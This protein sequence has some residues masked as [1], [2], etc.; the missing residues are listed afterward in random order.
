MIGYARKIKDFNTQ[1]AD[2]NITMI[3]YENY[4]HY[5]SCGHRLAFS[6]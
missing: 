2:K 1:V 4:Y 3:H 5:Y 6:V